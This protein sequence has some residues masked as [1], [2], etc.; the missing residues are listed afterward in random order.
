MAICS[1]Q[2]FVSSQDKLV[3]KG[4]THIFSIDGIVTADTVK[5]YRYI[6]MNPNIVTKSTDVIKFVP[7]I[8]DFIREVY[9]YK[10]KLLFVEDT[11]D[12]DKLYVNSVFLREAILYSLASLFKCSVYDMW[13]LINN[14]VGS[15]Y[16]RLYISA[17]PRSQSAS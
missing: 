3:F 10:G 1:K 16:G 4:F 6:L 2:F 8:F 5:R 7:K 15:C 9:V 11:A 14:Q 12:K 17:F 13:M